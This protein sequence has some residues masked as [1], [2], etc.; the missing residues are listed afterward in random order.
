MLSTST[1][2]ELLETIDA[3][4]KELKI[5]EKCEVSFEV[6][7]EDFR[8]IDEDLFYRL[9]QDDDTEFVPSTEDLYVNYGERLAIKIKKK[10]DD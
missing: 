10:D 6:R 8:K 5:M 9:R 1:I 2:T 7:Q 3:K 4:L